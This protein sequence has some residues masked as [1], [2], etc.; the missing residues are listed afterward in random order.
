MRNFFNIQY[1][2]IYFFY[3]LAFFFLAIICFGI[4][5]DRR[6]GLPW[7]L[8]GMFGLIHG[9]NE[10]LEIFPV[11]FGS[12]DAFSIGHLIILGLSYLFL[13]EFARSGFS[14]GGKT[15]IGV[16][17]YPIILVLVLLGGRY[18]FSEFN[19]ASRYFIGFPAG[20]FASLVIF[21]G[22]QLEPAGR[23]SLLTLSIAMALYS[24]LAGL[25]VPKADFI[26]AKWLNADSFYQVVGMPVQLVRGVLAMICAMALWFFPPALPNVKLLPKRYTIPFKP[27][28]WM[29]LLTLTI[30]VGM[31]WAFTNYFDYY[32]GVQLIKNIQ[33]NTNSPINQLMTKL[34]RLERIAIVI[35][36]ASSVKT[37]LTT[38]TDEDL[39]K[40][41]AIIEHYQRELENS[42]CL[43]LDNQG[44]VVIS[45]G[46]VFLE[47][48]KNQSFASAVYFK[49]AMSGKTGYHFALGPTYNERIY[50]VSFPVKDH[51]GKILGV[52]VL[53]EKLSAARIIKYRFVGIIITMF[54]C[55]L[56]MVFFVVLK[57][58][59]N[60]ILFMKEVNEQLNSVDRMKNDFLAVVSHELKTPLTSIN[61]AATILLRGWPDK[62]VTQEREKEL[63]EIIL[64][65]THRQ[66]RMVKDLLDVS[67]IEAGAM[68][69]EIKLTD[70]I[71]LIRETVNTFQPLAEKKDI[72]LL[73]SVE[74]ESLLISIDP[75]HTHR[76]LANLI[77]NAIK[78]TPDH[79]EVMVKV[80]EIRRNVKISVSD[81]GI[82]IIEEDIKNIFNKFY[83]SSDARV[84]Q[85][86]GSGLG[87]LITKGLVEAQ[88]GKIW[89][90][91]KLNKGSSFNFTLP[92]G[93]ED[94]GDS[95]A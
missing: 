38:R 18:G 62:R 93:P 56:T 27:S 52:V 1:D 39:E 2:Y 95:H 9:I 21:R 88:G 57:N 80:K 28:K 78:F 43:L 3:G 33:I 72:K 32:A 51:D 11:I 86:G 77:H 91:S 53:K 16:W 73:L 13:F 8:L 10:W 84:R 15:I 50:S 47:N 23:K 40:A 58:R 30:L 36:K 26:W 48:K 89:I 79:G 31:G 66:T 5:K 20:I 68:S 12:S 63:L 14:R 34:T 19:I 90:E 46:D 42:G 75:D 35:S 83:R 7:F 45:V 54:V 4:R 49:Q 71:V 37:T 24:I 82:G 60:Q 81:T 29:I 87:L 65:N 94:K 85:E 25:I 74:K 17:I 69:M 70:L 55:L 22:A 6:H 67:K 64:N 41:A 92:L 59:E 76:I 61:N 44:L